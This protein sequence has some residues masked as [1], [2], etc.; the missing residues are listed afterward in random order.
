MIPDAVRAGFGLSGPG[1]RLEGGE[2]TSVVVDGVVC[3]P[4][5]D[6]DVASWCQELTH[7]YASASEVIAPE[8]VRAPDGGFVVDGWTASRFIPGLRSLE[9]DPRRVVGLAAPVAAMIADAAT[10]CRP[11]SAGD[12]RRRRLS[13]SITGII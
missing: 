13:A 6:A 11:P 10:R 7:E 2:G 5:L 4:V 12:T 8:P 9:T 3:K 1:R